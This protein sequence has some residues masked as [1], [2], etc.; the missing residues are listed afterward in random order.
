MWVMLHTVLAKPLTPIGGY[1]TPGGAFDVAIRG[2]Y[3]YVADGLKGLQIID[4]S[5]PEN[6]ALIGSCATRGDAQSVTVVGNYAYIAD[7]ISGMHIVDVSDPTAPTLVATYAYVPESDGL[8]VVGNY[9]YIAGGATGLLI[10]DVSDPHKPHAVGRYDTAGHAFDVAVID[11][12][13]YVADYSAGLVVLDVSDPTMPIF[14]GS[15]RGNLQAIGVSVSGKYAY[16]AAGLPGLLIVDISN[17]ENCVLAGSYDTP[18]LNN[19]AVGVYVQWPYAFVA[20]NLA[21]LEVYDVTDPKSIAL[22]GRYDTDGDSQRLTVVD[23]LVYLADYNKGLQIFGF[24]PPQKARRAQGVP[25]VVNGFVVGVSITDPGYGYPTNPPPAVRIRDIS[26]ADAT[27]HAVV[28][29]GIVEQ[30]VI[31]NAG[32][33]YSTNATVVIAPPPFSPTLKLEVLKVALE[34]SVVLGRKYQLEAS[35]DLQAWTQVGTAF[36][37]EA[38]TIRQEFD[39]TTTGRFFKLTEVP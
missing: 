24:L 4:I 33:G 18:G 23:G 22:V 7:H 2:K 20:D 12:R 35:T 21:G 11:N 15:Y 17:P 9:A 39:V 5:T 1:D 19:G 6:C 29:D 14:L 13:A 3:A 32:R 30:I 26:G 31:D 37:A 16:L 36:V 27:A 28:N 25:Q 34:M 8:T 38:D 10:L